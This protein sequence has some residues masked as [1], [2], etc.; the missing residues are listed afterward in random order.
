M[1]KCPECDDELIFIEKIL[2]YACL[3]CRKKFTEYE[4]KK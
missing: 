3:K 1:A 2:L 4:V